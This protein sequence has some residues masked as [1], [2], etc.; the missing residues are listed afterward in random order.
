MHVFSLSVFKKALC[1]N[2]WDSQNH[3]CR[4]GPE[5]KT[6]QI[7]WEAR[8]CPMYWQWR[9]RSKIK[10]SACRLII[11][12]TLGL[13]HF[14]LLNSYQPNHKNIVMEYWHTN[15]MCSTGWGR[16]GRKRLTD[17]WWCGEGK[18]KIF[19]LHCCDPSH[20]MSNKV[21]HEWLGHPWAGNLQISKQ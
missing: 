10:A 9:S 18:K 19:L 5:G 15:A 8:R 6:T 2:L 3:G 12:W 14:Y 21:R 4:R 20:T 16:R 1:F 7:Y 17:T 11:F 13:T